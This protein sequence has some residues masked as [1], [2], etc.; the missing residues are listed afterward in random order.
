ILQ[1][2][3]CGW[4]ER[5]V[6]PFIV[7]SAE[8]SAR[9]RTEAPPLLSCRSDSRR[10]TADI[11]SPL[12]RVCQAR[13]ERSRGRAVRGRD[14]QLCSRPE[15]EARCPPLLDTFALPWTSSSRAHISRPARRDTAS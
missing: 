14:R 7:D 12:R 13:R 10:Y 3:T 8:L 15:K 5:L 6:R 2:F 4:L 9:E 1:S 11:S